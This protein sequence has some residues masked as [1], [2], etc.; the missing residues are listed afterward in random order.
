V[1]KP[2][3]VDIRR[4]TDQLRCAADDP[5]A[6]EMPLASTFS[7]V[8]VQAER[9]ERVDREVKVRALCFYPVAHL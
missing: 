8:D 3:R 9:V 5:A 7:F 6:T 2:E 4:P 1:L